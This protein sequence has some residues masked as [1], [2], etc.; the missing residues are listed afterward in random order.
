MTSLKPPGVVRARAE[1]LDL[2]AAPLGVA[3]E[4]AVEVAGPDRGLV[5]ADALADLDDHVLAV[6]RVGRRERDA[7]LLLERVAALLELGNEL[8]QV[9]VAASGVEVFVDQPPLLREL[10]RAFELLQ[11]A[12]GR[13]RLAVVVVDGRVG[14][15]LLR[16]LVRAFELVDELFDVAGHRRLRLAL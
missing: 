11:A 16:L 4:G 15:A 13:G 9:A 8:A 2:E 14:H 7:Q 12:S 1:L 5:A 3:R 10:V 6:G